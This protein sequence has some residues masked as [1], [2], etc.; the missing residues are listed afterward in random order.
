MAP[1]GAISPRRAQDRRISRCRQGLNWL[2]S[3]HV[4]VSK[5][6]ALAQFNG[7]R[8]VKTWRGE[9]DQRPST[10][11]WGVYDGRSTSIDVFGGPSRPPQRRHPNV[12]GA[13]A[14]PAT[15][16][17]AA[18]KPPIGPCPRLIRLGYTGDEAR[19]RPFRVS[20]RSRRCLS[21]L[22]SARK[23][24][25]Q[26]LSPLHEKWMRPLQALSPHC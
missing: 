25:G 10:R 16:S 20:V 7:Y 23:Q 1:H 2:R 13:G 8:R 22:L 11:R 5:R 19:P 12:D 4:E 9:P 26:R 21:P 17:C 15:G 3:T 24:R 14:T 6:R 18:S